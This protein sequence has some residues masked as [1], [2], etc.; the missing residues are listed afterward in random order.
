MVTQAP[1]DIDMFLYDGEGVLML[2]AGVAR[3]RAEAAVAYGYRCPW[4]LWGPYSR[5]TRYEIGARLVLTA[6]R[7]YTDPRDWSATLGIEV[8]PVGALR[9]LLGIR[10]LY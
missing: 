2:R 9:Y 1:P 7:S 8:E 6:T 3:T 5:T 10:S 4:K